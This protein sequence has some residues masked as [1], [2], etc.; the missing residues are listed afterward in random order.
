MIMPRRVV[1]EGSKISHE[2]N[3]ANTGK[4]TAHYVISLVHY[5]MKDDGSIEAMPAEDTSGRFA[6]NYVRFFPRTV[7]LAPNEAQSI[8]VQL[9]QKNELENGEYRSHLYFRAVPNE[10]DAKESA[11]TESSGISVRITPVFG[12]AIPVIIHV[13][14]TTTKVGMSH[15]SFE[16]PDSTTHILKL[17][18][19]RTGN[20]SAYG[21]ITVDHI[22]PQ[23]TVTRVG[24][25]Q[26]VAVYTPNEVRHVKMRLNK[27]DGVDYT[28]GKLH[29]IYKPQESAT[30]N[31][32]AQTEL[33]LN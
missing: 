13:G 27:V 8:R 6:D 26:G 28:K 22:S 29:I 11:K 7:T 9:S 16:M 19:L 20:M 14:E 2:L 1:F 21:D 32:T 12:I 17:T 15:C 33:Y 25:V 30:Y 24:R 5:R 23:G 18:L 4:D 31:T 3:L 10:T